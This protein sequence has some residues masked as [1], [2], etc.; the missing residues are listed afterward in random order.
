VHGVYDLHDYEN[1]KRQA[2]E[3]LANRILHI[4]DPSPNVVPFKHGVSA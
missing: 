3:A 4:V 1:E 2:F